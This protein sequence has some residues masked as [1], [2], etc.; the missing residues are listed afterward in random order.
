M[1]GQL[2]MHLLLAGQAHQQIKA[3]QDGPASGR[4][5]ASTANAPHDA[6]SKVAADSTLGQPPCPTAVALPKTGLVG[7]AAF[8]GETRWP[9]PN[10]MQTAYGVDNDPQQIAEATAVGC[11]CQA[12]RQQLRHRQSAIQS[13]AQP[14]IQSAGSRLFLNRHFGRHWVEVLP[15]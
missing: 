2:T 9:V 13:N 4:T 10:P 11:S 14:A 15:M 3:T 6:T 8:A 1:P 5:N 7:N 12:G